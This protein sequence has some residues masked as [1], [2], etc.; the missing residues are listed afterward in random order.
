MKRAALYLRVSTK[1]QTT[2]NQRMELERVAQAKGWN[3]T[4]IYEDEG[5]SGAKGRDKRPG[6]DQ[7]LKDAV[8]AKFDVVMA[9]DVSRLGRSLA[10]LVTALDELHAHGIDLYLHQQAIDTTTPSGK[11]MF[12][13]TGVFAEFERSM[14]QERVKAGLLRAKAAGIKLGRPTKL[15]NTEQIIADRKTG[16]TTRQIAQKYNISIG[17][18]HNIIKTSSDE[19][20]RLP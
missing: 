6:Y 15:L 2:D 11:A 1:E 16:K 19:I 8:R 3:I 10:G 12:Q 13:M 20:L 4:V 17:K 18:A 7:L 5:I 9:W 14:I